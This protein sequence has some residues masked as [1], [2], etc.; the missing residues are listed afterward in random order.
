M[1]RIVTLGILLVFIGVF[2]IIAGSLSGKESRVEF[3][4]GGFI[5]PIPFGFASNRN[6]LYF[7]VGMLMV[8]L[9]LS[10]FLA[11]SN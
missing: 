6:M 4:F 2:I 7:V 5:G 10:F 3:G 9:I 8:I 1:D 11:H